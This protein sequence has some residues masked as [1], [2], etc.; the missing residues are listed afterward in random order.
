MWLYFFFKVS[1]KYPTTG[2]LKTETTA[3]ILTTEKTKA[4]KEVNIITIVLNRQFFF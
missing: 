2:I 1:N 4:D 3:Y